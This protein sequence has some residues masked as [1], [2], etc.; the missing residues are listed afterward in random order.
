MNGEPTRQVHLDF[1]TSEH[2]PDIGGEFSKEQFQES[3]QLGHVNLINVFAKCH[4]SWS[5]YPTTIGNP[6]PNLQ[7]DLLGGQIEA[8][9]EIGVEAPVYFTGGWSAHDAEEHPE[10]CM[11]TINGDIVVSETWPGDITP[12][13]PKPTFQWKELCVTGEYHEL[14]M[15][16]TE[17][18]CRSYSVDGFWY[19]IYRPH[20]LCYCKRCRAGMAAEG[21]DVDD[22]AAVEGYRARTIITHAEALTKVIHSYHPEASIYFNGITAI[23]RPQ[24]FRHHIFRVNSKNDLEDLPTTWGG[25]DKFPLRS[26]IFHR[27]GKPV[28]AM[29]GKFHTAWGEFG[30][31]KDPEALR[32]EAASMIAYG[33][34]C[35]FGDH[36]H[37]LGQMDRTTYEN[38]GH[39]FAYV[40]QIEGYGIGGLP[41]ST[42]G[43]WAS[44]ELEADEGLV[45]LLLD[46]QIDFDVV[47]A[48]D[49]L[50]RFQTI[51]VPSHTG[52]LSGAEEQVR[53]FVENGGSLALLGAG[54]LNAAGDAVAVP[55]GARFLRCPN[56]DVDYTLVSEALQDAEARDES[57]HRPAKLPITPFLN[58]DVSLEF[59]LEP[60]AEVLATVEEPYFSRTYGHYCGHQNTPNRPGEIARPAAWRAGNVLVLA[61]PLDRMYYAHGAKVHR[62]VF[63]RALRMMHT[64]PMVEAGLPSAGRVSLLHQRAERRYVAH[65]LY[66]PPIERGRCLVIEDLPTLREVPVRLRMPSSVRGLSLVPGSLELPM[67]RQ[68]ATGTGP[69][70]W[71]IIETTVPELTGHC[72]IV[73]HY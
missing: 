14:M 63:A 71:E 55:C 65:L 8:C 45:R 38:I 42:L 28:V 26:K 10:W 68:A 7:T 4:H 20:I 32:F 66:G 22:T 19:D 9:H 2:L 43:L 58:Y 21:I 72:A 23:E 39:A 67:R 49:D 29:S 56:S 41:A 30:G 53:A 50:S 46:E 70:G 69:A 1:H 17:E 15:A 3:L 33:A 12:R 6:H 35:N 57:L 44:Y 52:T 47:A 37:P 24:S 73:A 13:T 16:Q 36:L 51:V 54:A 62:D 60:A 64:A 25:Y 18:I 59:E 61:H 48:G 5:Y 31:F 40:E 34:R 11:R 27:E